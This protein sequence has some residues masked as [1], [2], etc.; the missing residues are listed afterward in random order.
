MCLNQS[1][2]ICL[3]H[4]YA[5]TRRLSVVKPIDYQRI[6]RILQNKTLWRT[7]KKKFL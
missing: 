3:D 7:K 5:T 1:D 2:I 4:G 6:D